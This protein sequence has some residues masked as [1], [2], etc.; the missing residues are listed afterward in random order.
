MKVIDL[1][2]ILLSAAEDG[3]GDYE[4][5]IRVT[6]ENDFITTNI[7]AL[8]P[9]E[10]DDSFT[11]VAHQYSPLGNIDLSGMNTK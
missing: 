9:R 5:N 2:H 6:G 10:N 8:V 11:L 3:Y 4:L 7:D 1:M